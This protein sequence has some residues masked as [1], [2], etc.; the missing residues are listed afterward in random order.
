[1]YFSIHTTR[2]LL[3]IA[4]LPPAERNIGDAVRLGVE[5]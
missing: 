2:N 1:M 3:S 4:W 5:A